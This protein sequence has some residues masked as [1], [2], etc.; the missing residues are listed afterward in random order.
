[1]RPK[2]EK[3]YK[4]YIDFDIIEAHEDL[5]ILLE[6][7][8]HDL[9]K[10]VLQGSKSAG[11]RSRRSLKVVQQMLK[12]MLKNCLKAERAAKAAQKPHG[13]KIDPVG[14]KVMLDKRKLKIKEN[15][16]E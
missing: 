13:N 14:I 10:S 15:N 2:K 7:L 3:T 1:M 8:R 11:L 12:N 6:D 16:N 9:K 5:L 4:T